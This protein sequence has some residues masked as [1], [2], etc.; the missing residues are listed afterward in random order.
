MIKGYGDEPA[1]YEFHTMIAVWWKSHWIIPYGRNVFA[2]VIEILMHLWDENGWKAP[3]IINMNR[4]TVRVDS[5]K[6]YNP[7]G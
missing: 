1:N 2:K 7:Y 3:V 4:D 6:E 5:E